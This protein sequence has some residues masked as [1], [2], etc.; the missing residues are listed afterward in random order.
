M[1]HFLH[2]LN[3]SEVRGRRLMEVRIINP[4]V[5]GTVEA[6]KK[7]AFLD[8]HPGKAYLKESNVT[9]GDVSGI[10]GITGDATGS[11]AISFT[12]TCICNIV[13]GLRGELHTAADREVFDAVREITRMILAVAGTSMEKEGL[14]VYAALP[15]VVY[16]K[17]HMIE[18]LLDSPSITIPFSTDEETFFI[19]ICIK[20]TATEAPPAVVEQATQRQIPGHVTKTTV[21]EVGP[22]TENVPAEEGRKA[23]L[24]K[25]LTEAI[26]ARGELMKQ[27]AEKPFMEISQRTKFKKMIPALDAKIKRLKMDTTAM[28]MMAKITRDGLENPIIATHYQHHDN[29]KR[30]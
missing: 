4:F 12:E 24:Q 10:I 14:K 22:D 8:I 28:E 16:G 7:I 26:V 17:S 11:L 1:P 21:A 2:S 25:Q 30:R 27:L 18:P 13:S 3:V 29:Q 5:H 19:D 20:S 23:L 15:T 6:M 9:A